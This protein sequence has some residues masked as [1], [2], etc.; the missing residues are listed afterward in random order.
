MTTPILPNPPLRSPIVGPRGEVAPGWATFFQK[1]RNFLPQAAV[2]ADTAATITSAALAAPV[3]AGAWGRA[4]FAPVPAAGCDWR[5]EPH[6]VQAAPVAI[7]PV[8]PVPV[9]DSAAGGFLFL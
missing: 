1:V 8:T 6:P 7:E 4:E 9:E 2:E 3:P 5:C